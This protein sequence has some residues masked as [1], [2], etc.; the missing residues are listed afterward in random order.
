MSSAPTDLRARRRTATR[1]EVR[2]AALTLFEQRGVDRTTVDEIAHA[3][4]ISQRTFFR[5]FATKE[6]CVL[7][8]MY[9]FEEAVE[10]CLRTADPARLTL[11]DL[12]AVLAR[13]LEGI[14]NDEQSE[15]AATA[16]RIHTLVATDATLSRAALARHAD[17]AARAMALLEGRCSPADRARIRMILQI[18]RISLQLAFEEWVEACA[19]GSAGSDLPSVYRAVCARVR[20]L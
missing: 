15:I 13:T 1:L 4:G 2:E 12:E 7:F 9:G 18:A 3:A 20:T 17:N 19:P 6:E 10:D 11:A 14:R 16:L 5:Y 8:D